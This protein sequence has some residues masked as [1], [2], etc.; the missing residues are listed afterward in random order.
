M[1]AVARLVGEGWTNK[2]IAGHFGIT[3]RRVQIIITAIAYRMGPAPGEHDRV[4]IALHWARD[5]A[6]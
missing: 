4:R 2:R 3:E 6:A 1:E 5:K